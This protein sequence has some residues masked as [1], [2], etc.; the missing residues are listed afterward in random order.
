MRRVGLLGLLLAAACT[1]RE[2][3]PPNLPDS[4]M[5]AVL[6]D[7]H[8]ADARAD[9]TG[10]PR[11]S[12]RAAALERHGLDTLA[13]GRAVAYFAAHPEAYLPLYDAALDRLLRAEHPSAPAAPRP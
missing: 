2:A 4:V 5:V 1:P 10:A 3:P 7:V 12:L 9:R 6:V 11:D 8:L 13:F